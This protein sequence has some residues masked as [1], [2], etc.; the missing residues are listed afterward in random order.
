MVLAAVFLQEK[1]YQ[2]LLKHK[3]K[4]RN[5]FKRKM[6]AGFHFMLKYGSKSLK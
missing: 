1:K 4:I 3:I 5:F 6:F 2:Q